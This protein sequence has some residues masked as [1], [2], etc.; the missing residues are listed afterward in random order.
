MRKLLCMLLAALLIGSVALATAETVIDGKEVRNITINDAGLNEAPEGVSPTTG[1]LLSELAAAAPSNATGLAVTGRY[2]PMLVQID[3]ADNGIGIR[4]PWGGLW[5]DIIYESP[6]YNSG[7]TRISMLFSDVIPDAVG[8]VRSARLGHVWLREEWDAGF[9]FYGQQE[10]PKTNVKAEF[11]RLGADD[12]GVLFSGTDG[13]NKPW[14]KFYTKVQSLKNPHDKSGNAAEISKLI[15]ETHT[16]P[17]HTFLF[18]D[19]PLTSGDTANTITLHWLSYPYTNQLVYDA[20]RNQY[21]RYMLE[22]DKKGNLTPHMWVDFYTLK[23]ETEYADLTTESFKY[24]N[25]RGERQ[26]ISFNNIII[27]HLQCDWVASNAPVTYNVGDAAYFGKNTFVAQG[28]ADFFMNGQHVAG[29][30]KRN[31]MNSRTVFYGP[32]GNEMKLQ[33]GRTL[34][35]MIPFNAPKADYPDHFTHVSYE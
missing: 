21:Y 27:Q 1:R 18:T 7:D 20:A 12:K 13:S 22:E 10:F 24:K 8:P 35:V 30:W 32:D 3:N 17:N 16:A 29:V 28:N 4:S 14:K 11:K 33:R 15:P 26:P 9:M 23:D 31:D 34:I 5:A 6:L 19:E 25:I 2:M